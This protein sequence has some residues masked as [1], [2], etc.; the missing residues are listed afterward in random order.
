MLFKHCS[1]ERK[2]ERK[3]ERKKRKRERKMKERTDKHKEQSHKLNQPEK[4]R[5]LKKETIWFVLTNS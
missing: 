4:L 3:G 5:N 2:K 1:L